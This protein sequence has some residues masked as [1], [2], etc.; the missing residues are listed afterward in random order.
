LHDFGEWVEHLSWIN[1]MSMTAWL[2]STVSVIH[3]F[4]FF[5][6][7]GGAVLV[8][9]RVMGLAATSKPLTKVAD[10]IYPWMWVAFW[11]AIISGSLE[12]ATDA[13]DYLPNFWYELKIF[14]V[15][16]SAIVVYIV[17]RNIPKWGQ[18]PAIPAGAKALA[19]LS[20]LLWIGSILAGVELPAISGLG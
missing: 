1:Y 13:G 19:L 10:Q 12:A 8:D 3:Y 14:T 7:V 20:V 18:E 17:Q 5:I 2:F 9:L 11:L 16:V 4:S 6:T 15:I